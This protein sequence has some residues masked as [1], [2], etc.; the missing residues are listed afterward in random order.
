MSLA[1]F[2]RTAVALFALAVMAALATSPAHARPA[3]AMKE[4]V[5]CDYCHVNP[6]GPR[7]FRGLYYR[8]HNHSFTEFDNVYEAKAAGVPADAMAGD[9]VTKVASYPNVKVAPALNFVVKDID[10]KTVNLARYQ[11]IVILMVNVASFCGNTPQYA[12]LQKIYDKYKDKGFVILGFPANE[13]N[14]QEPGDNKTIKEF[15]TS[16]YNVTFPMFSKIVVK[17]DGQVPLYKYFTDKNTDPKFGGDIEWNFAKFLIGRNGEIVNRFP[18]KA[19]PLKTADIT[20]AIE[21]ELAVK[22]ETAS[23]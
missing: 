3:F 19:D 8:A 7:N 14:H 18:A 12:S 11:G 23:N 1:R 20:E 21:K 10:G 16:K 22:Q 2:M 6:G 15:C 17:G 13:F 9:A 4:G 5:K